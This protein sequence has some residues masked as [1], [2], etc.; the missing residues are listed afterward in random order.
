LLEEP[1]IQNL[2]PVCVANASCRKGAR[3]RLAEWISNRKM[4][5][6]RI[7]A[8]AWIALRRARTTELP[9]ILLA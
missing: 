5:I 2:T 4:D 1:Q 3:K 8:F 6:A 9:I 7:T